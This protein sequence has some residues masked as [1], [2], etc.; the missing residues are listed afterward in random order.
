LRLRSYR[1]ED[2]DELVDLSSAPLPPADT[3][4]P[5]RLLPV[6]DAILLAH[7]RR[8]GVLHEKY[9]KLVF[10]TRMPH[11]VNTFLVDGQVAG[12]WRFDKGRVNIE[13]FERIDASARRQLDEEADRMAAYH[14]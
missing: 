1:S 14:A 11:S 5:V 13:P 4:A 2:G 7:A 8:A 12:T 10:N 9:R 6:Y 3:E